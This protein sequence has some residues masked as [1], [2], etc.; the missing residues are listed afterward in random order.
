V[1]PGVCEAT[2]PGIAQVESGSKIEPEGEKEP[3]VAQTKPDI[4]QLSVAE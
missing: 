1:K 3:G 4:A 2:K